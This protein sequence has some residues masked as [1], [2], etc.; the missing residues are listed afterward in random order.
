[1][2]HGLLSFFI[3]FFHGFVEDISEN[4]AVKDVKS[5]SSLSGTSYSGLLGFQWVEKFVL[6][7]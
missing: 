1:M 4:V 7:L 2:D 5:G 3:L 6:L